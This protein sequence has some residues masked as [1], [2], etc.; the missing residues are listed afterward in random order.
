MI[1]KGEG[2]AVLFVAAGHQILANVDV[3]HFQVKFAHNRRAALLIA[4]VQRERANVGACRRRHN[5]F[6]RRRLSGSQ[7]HGPNIILIT[8][9]FKLL[10]LLLFFYL[11][12]YLF[13]FFF[14]LI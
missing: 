6:Q 12:I 2:V 8:I 5:D 10:L 3:A 4:N 9:K 13:F 11:F 1:R 14:F 7:S